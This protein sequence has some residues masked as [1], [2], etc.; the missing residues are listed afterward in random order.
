M[1]D[2]L[3]LLDH[4]S[5]LQRVLQLSSQ[6][7]RVLDGAGLQDRDRRHV[8]QGLPG[9]DGRLVER[10]WRGLEDVQGADAVGS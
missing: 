1:K 6:P 3:G 8:G 2:P 10:P 4:H 9:E 7:G 5:A